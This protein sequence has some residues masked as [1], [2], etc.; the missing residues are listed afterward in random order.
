M[1]KYSKAL[2]G[3][4]KGLEYH[5]YIRT[6]ESDFLR[7]FIFSDIEFPNSIKVEIDYSTPLT[8]AEV[9][10]LFGVLFTHS[11]LII[12]TNN[13]AEKTYNNIIVPYLYYDTN[14]LKDYILQILHY[15]DN[16][17]VLYFTNEKAY[18][19]RRN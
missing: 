10:K 19:K 9:V 13:E 6:L 3:M 14:D 11:R 18:I 12:H 8:D 17:P 15:F 7:H 16:P 2:K 1:S 4:Y 5:T